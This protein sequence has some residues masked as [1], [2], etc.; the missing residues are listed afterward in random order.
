M[1]LI[2]FIIVVIGLHSS[3]AQDLIVTIK[4]DSLNSKIKKIKKD[5]IYFTY[6]N[7]N[8]VMNTLIFVDDVKYYQKNYFSKPAIPPEILKK[9]DTAYQKIR[10]GAF[11]GISYLISK[12]NN[13]NPSWEPIKNFKSYHFGGDFTYFRDEYVGFGIKYSIF[14][15]MSSVFQ[16]NYVTVFHYN[17]Y[18]SYTFITKEHGDDILIHQIGPSITGRYITKNKNIHLI[19]TFSLDYIIYKNNAMSNP[20]YY[21]LTSETFGAFFNLGVDFIFFKHLSIGTCFSYSF[22]TINQVNYDDGNTK[23]RLTVSEN[24]SRFDFSIALRWLQ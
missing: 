13:T 18:L 6:L 2:I 12:I 16:K 24:I 20:K 9:S 8:E 14:R 22:G 21:T 5:Y 1:R 15:I 23:K 7:K 19:S 3:W 11:G 4:G 10:V 17:N